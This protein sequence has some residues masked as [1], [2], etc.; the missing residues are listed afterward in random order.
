MLSI[1]ELAEQHKS[2]LIKAA[3]KIQPRVPPVLQDVKPKNW[4]EDVTIS[5]ESTREEKNG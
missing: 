4:W 2:K 1:L 3:E 5:K